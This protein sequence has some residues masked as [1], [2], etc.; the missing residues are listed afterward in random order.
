[1]E[2]CLPESGLDV[3]VARLTRL[4]VVSV[5]LVMDA[6]E[7]AL[8]GDHAGLAVLTGAA[9]EGGT[10]RRSGTELAEAMERRGATL[11]VATGWEGTSVS[12][13]CL[14]EQ[15]DPLLALLAEA[16]LEPAFPPEEVERARDQRL[17]AIRQ[18][19]MDPPSMVSDA[20]A[21]RIFSSDSPYARPVGGTGASVSAMDAPAL[22]RFADGFYRPRRAGLV[23]A[24]DVSADEVTAAV[25]AH[26]GD[27]SGE[28]PPRPQPRSR[29]QDQQRRVWVV[30]RPDSVQTE[31][32]IGHV[33]AARSSP[34]FFPLVVLNTVLGGAFT[35]RLNLNLRERHGFT[36]GVRSRFSFRRLPG[37]FQVATSVGVDV[38]ADA[39]RET[40]LE[41]DK[42]V[43]SGPTPEETS[44]ARDFAAGV[45][46]LQ[47]ETTGQVAARISEQ[48]VFD[49][50]DDYYDTY[51]DRIRAVTPQRAAQAGRRHIRPHSAQVV[52]VGNADRIVGPLEALE[53]GPLQVIAPEA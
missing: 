39:V 41:L 4:P 51:R 31:I 9:L 5:N 15:L 23:F 35:S 14:A 6:G 2:R 27:W 36:Y 49:L 46:P 7:G 16:V 52:L 40:F 13:S 53:L 11:G 25:R 12:V 22:T 32:R 42:L 17:A 18:R 8:D 45:F 37:S 30:H 43:D 29:P 47:L 26:F 33:G 3:R 28:P 34:D 19:R 21:R 24:G 10:S 1:M 44:A 50:P 20:A 38:T 48:I